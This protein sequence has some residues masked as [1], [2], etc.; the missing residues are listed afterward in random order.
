MLG[1]AM[2]TMKRSS[3]DRNTP[4]R[5]IR[6]VRAGRARSGRRSTGP[7]SEFC[8][9]THCKEE[10][11]MKQRIRPK[12]ALCW[13][14]AQARLP[15]PVLPGR[16]DARGGGR[17]VDAADHPRRL[18][19]HPA[20]RRPPAR[21][22]RG[23]QRP[24]GPPGAA[25][26]GGDPREAP[27]QERP[28]RCEYRLTEKGADLWPVLVALLQ[29]GDRYGLEGERPMILQHRGCGGELDDRRRCTGLRG[30]RHGHRGGRHPDRRAPPGVRRRGPVRPGL[31]APPGARA[32]P[33][34]SLPWAA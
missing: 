23:A 24:P 15:Q 26:R 21:P 14:D 2:L 6:A 25:G 27:Y 9:E 34:A 16:L 11:C 28:L 17:A 3:E 7:A 29:W 31:S 8:H 33:R 19:G 32:R 22:G 20:L 10:S 5:T 1:K 13:A 30:R 12:C 4:V 18:L